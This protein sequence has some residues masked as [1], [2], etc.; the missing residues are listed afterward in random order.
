[1]V[2]LVLFSILLSI[3]GALLFFYIFMTP[4]IAPSGQT[5]HYTVTPIKIIPTTKFVNRK[6]STEKLSSVVANALS[7]TKGTYA[8]VIKNIKSGDSYYINE[9]RQFQ[10]ASRY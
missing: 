1:M 8:I 2:K 5:K 6:K 7:G 9:H 4:W 3:V 10:A